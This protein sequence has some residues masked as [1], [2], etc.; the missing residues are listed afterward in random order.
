M[1]A[2]ASPNTLS[3][4]G[5]P[6]SALASCLGILSQVFLST[7]QLATSVCLQLCSQWPTTEAWLVSRLQRC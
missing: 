7:E 1:V 6:E 5:E 2:W 3:Q 4:L